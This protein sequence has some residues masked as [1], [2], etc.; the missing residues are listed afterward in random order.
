MLMVIMRVGV[1]ME[2][3]VAN[4]HVDQVVR[5]QIPALAQESVSVRGTV[6]PSAGRVFWMKMVCCVSSALYCYVCVCVCYTI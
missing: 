5:D 3:V 1:W 2:L 4:H 6:V